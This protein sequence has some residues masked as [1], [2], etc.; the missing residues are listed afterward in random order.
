VADVEKAAEPFKEQALGV[1]KNLIDAATQAGDFIK[2]QIPLVI[3]ELLAFSTAL[4]VCG[5]LASIAGLVG[6]CLWARFCIRQYKADTD[7]YSKDGW[8]PAGIFP[9]LIVA[10]PSLV[11]LAICVVSLLKITLAPRVWL[12]EYAAGLVR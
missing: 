3:Q 7:H 10:I 4:Y 11:M 6:V 5:I 8:F 2:D 1:L 12:I 9:S